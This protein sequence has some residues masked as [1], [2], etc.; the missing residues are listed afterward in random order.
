M[1]V[2]GF[3]SIVEKIIRFRLLLLRHLLRVTCM[4]GASFYFTS[5]IHT[6]PKAV[7]TWHY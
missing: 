1:C 3:M 7:I 2:A 5:E 4:N 6:H